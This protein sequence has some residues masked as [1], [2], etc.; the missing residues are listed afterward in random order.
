MCCSAA[1]SYCIVLYNYY[2]LYISLCTVAHIWLTEY[3]SN[4]LLAFCV[5]GR[6]L[7]LNQVTTGNLTWLQIT[8]VKKIAR[9][10]S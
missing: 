4:K 6:Q 7:H 2:I 9:T 3:I 10:Y 8:K 1:Y 5:K